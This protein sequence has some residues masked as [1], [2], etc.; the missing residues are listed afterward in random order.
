MRLN[1][2]ARELNISTA[3]IVT[4][5]KARN[6]NID[7]TPNTKVTPEQLELL[8]NQFSAVN[9]PPTPTPIKLTRTPETTTTTKVSTTQTTT[10]LS[11]TDYKTKTPGKPNKITTTTIPTDKIDTLGHVQIPHHQTTRPPITPRISP[12]KRIRKPL[13]IRKKKNKWSLFNTINSSTIH[14][15]PKR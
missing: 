8:T 6:I 12:R 1:Q 11:T 9:V 7:N 13:E 15:P 14:H 10:S 3:T 4:Y 2:I 5:L